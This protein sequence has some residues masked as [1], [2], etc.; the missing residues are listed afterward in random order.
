MRPDVDRILPDDPGPEPV[1]F[2]PRSSHLE[3]SLVELER[4]A[5]GYSWGPL[6]GQWREDFPTAGEL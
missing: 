4:S 1:E 6:N 5:P 2:D 3:R